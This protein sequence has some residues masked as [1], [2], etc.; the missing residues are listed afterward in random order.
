MTKTYTAAMIVIGNE[1]LS[2]RTQDKN[3][4][5]IAL[6]LG[7]VGVRFAEVRI[8]PD[9]AAKIVET[10]RAMKAEYDYVF[11]SGGIGPTHD[12]IT[13]ENVAAAC[14][15]VLVQNPQAYDILLAHYGAEELTD[16][17][18]KMAQIPVGASLIENPVSAAPGFCIDNVYVMAGVPRIMQAMMD[19]VAPTLAG[20][21][22]VQSR[23]VFTK[24]YESVIAPALGEIQDDFPDLDI[25][26]YPHFQNGQLGVSVVLRGVDE[27][28]LDKAAQ[29]VEAALEALKPQE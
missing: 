27:P 18:L 7:E 8:I 10:V 14:G 2:G 29:A 13:A 12:D 20:G 19:H 26:S 21:A 1:I 16:A 15:A 5:Y 3:I 9:I 6:K 25:G 17:R 23:T 22:V 4:N 28:M 11:T 24:L